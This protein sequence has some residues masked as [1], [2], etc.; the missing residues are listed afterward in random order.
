MAL[1]HLGA[2]MVSSLRVEARAIVIVVASIVALPM[3]RSADINS[4]TRAPKDGTVLGFVH[5]SVP[6]APLFG[7]KG[8][9][10]IRG[11]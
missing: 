10:S 3:R 11:R 7:I 2:S 5:S 1:V 4:K 8:R 6:F 9:N